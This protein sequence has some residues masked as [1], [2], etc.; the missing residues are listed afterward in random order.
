MA[1]IDLSTRN[2][3]RIN[4]NMADENI[5]LIEDA[6][7]AKEYIVTLDSGTLTMT[8]IADDT[9]VLTFSPDP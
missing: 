4:K 2:V 8:N 5:L 7:T 6:V 1:T 9:E 3:I